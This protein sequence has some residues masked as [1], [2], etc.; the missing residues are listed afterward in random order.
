MIRSAVSGPFVGLFLSDLMFTC[1]NMQGAGAATLLT[2]IFQMWHMSEKFRLGIRPSRMPVTTDYCSGNIT[3]ILNAP[4]AYIMYRF[5]DVFILSRLSSYW[6][7]SIRAVLTILL[8]LVISG[9][10][11]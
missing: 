2:T 5:D 3:K 10:T 7:N 9:L 6:S 11:G 8:A 1:V 4:F